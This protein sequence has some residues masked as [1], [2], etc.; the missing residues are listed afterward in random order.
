MSG[1]ET[2]KRPHSIWQS[3]PTSCTLQSVAL[4]LSPL[5]QGLAKMGRAI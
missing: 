5:T 4:N 2:N 3:I 1:K